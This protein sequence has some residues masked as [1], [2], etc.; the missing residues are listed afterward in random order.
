MLGNVC[1]DKTL[2]KNAACLIIRYGVR[3]RRF[4]ELTALGRDDGN[5]RCLSRDCDEFQ[6][7]NWS[8]YDDIS[9]MDH[10]PLTSTKHG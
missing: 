6:L 9:A 2:F 10:R 3:A 4:E 8:N 1:L 7:A 5:L